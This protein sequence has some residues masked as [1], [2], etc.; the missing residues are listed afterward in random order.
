MTAVK[1]FRIDRSSEWT[2]LRGHHETM[3]DAHLQDLFAAD[4]TR[5]DTMRLTVADLT[6][7]YSKNRLTAETFALLCALARRAGLGERIHGSPV[8]PELTHDSS[9]NALIRGYRQARGRG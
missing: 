7:D 8:P 5:G 1:P 3:G 9:T 4:P 6:L 2:A